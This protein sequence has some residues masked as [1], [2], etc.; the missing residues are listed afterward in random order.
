[1]LKTTGKFADAV[2]YAQQMLE[3]AEREQEDSWVASAL[4]CLAEYPG[5]IWERLKM[6][7]RCLD[8][9]CEIARKDEENLKDEVT[10]E[11]EDDDDDDDDDDDSFITRSSGPDYEIDN[12]VKEHPDVVDAIFVMGMLMKQKGQYQDAEGVFQQVLANREKI[13]GKEHPKVAET[14]N[15]LFLLYSM[16]EGGDDDP[17]DEL[18][19]LDRDEDPL[20]LLERAV[21]IDKK[22]YGEEHPSTALRLNNLACL[23]M[24]MERYEDA[25][26]L[27]QRNLAIQE[28]VYGKVHMDVAY[29]L[30]NL[31]ALY[32]KMG[33]YE[34]ALPLV[35]RSLAIREKTDEGEQ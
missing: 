21:A 14:L 15:A 22:V 9:R 23:Y 18:C 28:K 19:M 7:D 17:E 3:I 4:L 13:Y 26:P 10:K 25:L 5:D 33:R 6:I 29:G 2:P 1:M 35:K 12:K 32:Q 20:S 34:D 27:L 31:A 30:E 8:I 24:E 11:E 16:E